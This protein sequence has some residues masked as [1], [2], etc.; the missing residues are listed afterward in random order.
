MNLVN[1]PETP[2]KPPAQIRAEQLLANLN[3]SLAQRIHDHQLN[4]RIF[5]ESGDGESPDEIAAALGTNGTIFLDAA[6]ENLRHLSAL[7]QRVGKTLNDFLPPQSYLPRREIVA[8]DDGTL[9]LLPPP[10]GY[11]AWGQPIED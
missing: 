3:A 11:D 4:F 7:A 1:I 8:N 5:W 9:T 10:E 2:P 6:A